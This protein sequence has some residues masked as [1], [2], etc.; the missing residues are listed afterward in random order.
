MGTKLFRVALVTALGL[1][2]CASLAPQQQNQ[3]RVQS[4]PPNPR[5]IV[6]GGE[7]PAGTKLLVQL[8]H[9]IDL[10]A[11][12]GQRFSA[13]IAQDLL[14][15]SGQPVIPMGAE[16]RGRVL[17][18]RAGTQNQPAQVNLIL[19]DLLVGGVVHPVGAKIS[20]TLVT[21]SGNEPAIPRG[22]AFSMELERPIPLAA[23]QTRHT[24]QR[25]AAPKQ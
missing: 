9:A 15:A 1:G 23:L 4:L 21:T 3:T 24:A 5:P 20:S 7:I 6:R 13:R 19:D 11:Q 16:V 2:A 8:D 10:S 25:K 18:A 14:D 17:S 22:T 12:A